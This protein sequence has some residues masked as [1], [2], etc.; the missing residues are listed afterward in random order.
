MSCTYGSLESAALYFVDVIGFSVGIAFYVAGILQSDLFPTIYGLFL[1]SAWF[2]MW[3]FRI[4]L[5]IQLEDP[6]CPGVFYYA[7]P[8]PPSFYVASLATLLVMYRLW[9]PLKH[10][11]GWGSGLLLGGL[12]LAAPFTLLWFQRVL[13]YH[14]LIT[15]LLGIVSTAVFMVVVRFYV[16][17][18]MPYLVMQAPATWLGMTENYFLRVPHDRRSVK[19]RYLWRR[20]RH[21]G[22]RI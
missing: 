18:V 21:R 16:T 5:D 2:I 10:P 6:R 1:K 14:V 20:S 19:Y 22:I 17:P 9:Y 3:V 7:F 13:W 12:V 11:W 15:F 8:N 4:Y